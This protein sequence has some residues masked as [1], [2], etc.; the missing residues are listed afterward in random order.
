METMMADETLLQ[1]I[2]GATAQLV[3]DAAKLHDVVHGDA[4]I[5]VATEGGSVPSVA[6]AIADLN[7]AYA[8]DGTLAAA[9]AA[10][11]AAED[12]QAAAEAAAATF[13][14]DLKVSGDDMMA[15]KLEDKLSA[16]GLAMLST[17]NSGGNETRRVDVPVAT[18]SEAEAGGDNTKAM[19]PL[20][21]AQ[22]I[23]AQTAAEAGAARKA[24]A[25]LAFKQMAANN[26]AAFSLG[27]MVFDAYEDEV[28]VDTGNTTLEYDAAG[29]YANPP[30][31]DGSVEPLAN[32]ES[33]LDGNWEDTSTGGN[34]GSTPGTSMGGELGCEIRG[35]TSSYSGHLS[36]FR[37]AGSHGVPDVLPFVLT[38]KIYTASASQGPATNV[39]PLISF[40]ISDG[41]GLHTALT[42][43]WYASNGIFYHYNGSGYVQLSG[44]TPFSLNSWQT[45][46]FRVTAVTHDNGSSYA[47]DMTFAFFVDGVSH[48]SGTVPANTAALA[49]PIESNKRAWLGQWDDGGSGTRWHGVQQIEV[50]TLV[51]QAGVVR[52]KSITAEAVPAKARIYVDHKAITAQTI[53][54]HATVEISRDAGVS[55]SPGALT[56]FLDLGSGRKIYQTNE[57]D[58][59]GQPSGQD[60]R[61]RGSQAESY[62]GRWEGWGVQSD[63]QLTV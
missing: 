51:P 54:T 1:Q 40:A 25:T 26:E 35:H 24:I 46:E 11:Q 5:M 15:G 39:G 47:G 44:Q 57:I 59:T 41:A 17:L 31:N 14:G 63:V 23:A 13:D 34:S 32:F 55:W 20:R 42:L 2:E 19:T 12:A 27:N 48:W 18:Q 29:F 10:R 45:W 50:G 58:L 7:V 52:S 61:L 30:S 9:Q 33:T 21:T 36:L 22:A 3:A 28:A 60:I 16:S 62:E 8:S 38:A 49:D 56:E 37:G 53:N 6:K 43:Y 4:S